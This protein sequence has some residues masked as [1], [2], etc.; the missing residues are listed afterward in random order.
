MSHLTTRGLVLAAGAAFYAFGGTASAQIFTDNQSDIPQGN[1]NNNSAS[2]NVDFGDVDRDG[3]W[4]AIFADGGDGGNDQNR[5]WMNMGGAQGG[6]L[7]TFQDQTGSRFPSF[8]DDSRDIEF[9][10]FDNDGDIDIY[11]SNTAQ[12]SNQGNRW[13][14]NQGGAQHGAV[15]FYNDETGARWV[16]L[17]NAASSLPASAI[18]ADTFIDWSCDCDF[19][20]IDNDGDLD[21]VHS[22]Y[23]GAFNGNVP[24]RIFLNDGGGHFQEFNP[25][26]FKLSG[27]NINNGNPGLWCEGTQQ[28]NTTNSTGANCDIASSPLDI[29]LG[30]IDGDFDLDILHGARQELPRMFRNRLE[31]NG[32]STLSFRDVTGA[33]FP[34]GYSNGDGHYEQEMGDFD[35]DGDLDIYGLNW[36]AAGFGFDDVNFRNNGS[37]VYTQTQ[38]LPNSG[39]DDNEGDFFDYDNDGDLDIFVA[40]FSG[41]S[42]LYRNDNGNGS[43]SYISGST[44]SGSGLSASSFTGLDADACDVDGD[45]DYDVFQANDGSARNQFWENQLDIADTSAPY[46]PHIETVGNQSAAKGK[47]P[48]RAQVYDNAPYYITWYN[49]TNLIVSVNGFDLPTIKARSSAGQIFRAEIPKH[50]VGSVVAHW[51]STDEHGNMGSSSNLSYTGSFGSS[52]KSLIGTGSGTPQ[53]TLDVLSL[54]IPGQPLYFSTTGTPGNGYWLMY[55]TA[56]LNPPLPFGAGTLYLDIFN[57]VWSRATGG[58]FDANGKDT[59][60]IVLPGF[61]NPGGTLYWQTIDLTNPLG[62]LTDLSN[63]LSTVNQAG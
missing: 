29:D 10:D 11:V 9:V 53:M 49:D 56:P 12:L 17:G 7:G 59:R 30:D 41:T 23:G 39:S 36:Q 28:N 1:P 57:G 62:P 18:L 45:G 55:C 24:T 40:N 25:S 26:G 20:D 48:V 27:N 51:E 63:G 15:G 44:V 14:T 32:G 60:T 43:Y 47:I 35:G 3:D 5:I 19:G 6:S 31:E 16:G 33:V 38:V 2:E 58:T 61:F 34:S 42:R 8:S 22:T 50:L 21:L 13:W 52:F 4:D 37:G 46:I 54:P